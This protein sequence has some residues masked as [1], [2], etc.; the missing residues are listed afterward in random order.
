MQA[1]CL[2]ALSAV[3]ITVARGLEPATLRL[4]QGTWRFTTGNASLSAPHLPGYALEELQKASLIEDPRWGWA[5]P[6]C[7]VLSGVW[8]P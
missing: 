6:G 4:D 7:S 3:L 2:A 5:V 1:R 8:R